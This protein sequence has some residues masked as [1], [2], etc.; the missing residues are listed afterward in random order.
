[1]SFTDDKV[2]F[3]VASSCPAESW[4]T[5]REGDISKLAYYSISLCAAEQRVLIDNLIWIAKR[6]KDYEIQ[7]TDTR[8]V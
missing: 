2:F 1:M 4:E 3:G 6:A 5:L 8:E 7:R